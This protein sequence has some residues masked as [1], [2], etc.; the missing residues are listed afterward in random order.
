MSQGLSARR[1]M[2][3]AALLPVVCLLPFLDKPFNMDDPIFIWTAEQ[4]LQ[5]P[6]DF[7]GFK[8]NWYTSPQWMYEVNK[9]PPGVSY[10][11]AL[12][13][14]IFGFSE[15]ALHSALLI[16]TML[17]SIGCYLLAAKLC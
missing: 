7:F 14:G 1:G 2:V 15:I 8:L 6:S 12:T 17:A 9:N 5:H 13:G 10:Y 11:L 3:L 4:I 16:P